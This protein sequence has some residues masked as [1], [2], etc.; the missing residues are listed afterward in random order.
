MTMTGSAF[1]LGAGMLFVVRAALA[2]APQAA[3]TAEWRMR[4]PDSAHPA[5]VRA[6]K[7]LQAFMRARRCAEPLLWQLLGDLWCYESCSPR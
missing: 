6:A 4:T 7:D 5:I 3:V 2:A 1:R